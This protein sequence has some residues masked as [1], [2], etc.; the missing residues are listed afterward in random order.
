LP[1]VISSTWQAIDLLDRSGVHRALDETRPERIFHV[2]GA[3]RVDTA[4]ND[5]VPH[6][7]TNVMGTHHLLDSV[8]RLD[9]SCRIL[10]VSSA[11]VYQPGEQPLDENAPLVPQDP[12]GVSKLAQ[13]ELARRA[14]H[15]EG[16]D[17]VTARPFNHIGPRQ[18]P[19]FSVASF[20]RQI[21]WIEAGLAAPEI[22]VGNL[23]AR[24]DLTDVRDVVD[25]YVR[26]MMRGTA[27]RAYN[28]CSGRAVGMREVLE[29]LVGL[30]RTPVQV[31]VDPDRLRPSD[32]PVMLGD[33][34]RLRREVGW[35]PRFALS[36]TLHDILQ[37]WRAQVGPA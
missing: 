35:A 11:L 30:S 13:D 32:T 25:A 5:V 31:V 26:L 10:V 29:D 7:Q 16:L 36:E 6:L 14:C 15:D 1:E 27:G 34:S 21:A 37:W 28:I 19:A 22:H 9:L 12:Y 23:D 17:V 2:A 33:S 18:E 24:R 8:R 4:W 3:P 20:A